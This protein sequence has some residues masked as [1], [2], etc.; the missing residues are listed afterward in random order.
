MKS[1]VVGLSLALAA[2]AQVESANPRPKKIGS[3]RG[4][5]HDVSGDVYIVDARTLFVS[6][7]AG[8]RGER[9]VTFGSHFSGLF[10]RRRRSRRLLLGEQESKA[11]QEVARHH[12][13]LSLRGQ[14][15][16]VHR[17]ASAETGTT[18]QGE[19]GQKSAT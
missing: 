6:V 2:V 14:V 7:S 13:A 17:P 11:G 18:D 1:F 8:M 10:L 9:K 4:Y 12:L 15:L 5:D 16:Q 3:F 19:Q